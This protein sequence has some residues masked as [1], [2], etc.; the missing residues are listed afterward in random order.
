MDD[1][2]I[3]I[4]TFGNAVEANLAK[5]RL[6]TAGIRA[7]LADADTVD[8][9]W[10]LTG[11]VGGIKLQIPVGDEEVALSLLEKPLEA[12]SHRASGR[13]R[14]KTRKVIKLTAITRDGVRVA[15]EPAPEADEEDDD[16]F[17]SE[18]EDDE[19]EEETSEIDQVAERAWRGALIGILFLPIQLYVFGLLLHVIFSR[20][21]PSPALRWKVVAAAAINLPI[22]FLCFLFLTANNLTLK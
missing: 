21:K 10:Q 6:E 17:F 5:N 15:T 11:A 4:A 3:T 12:V 19:E 9:A 8:M 22:L 20:E 2:L 16:A 7:F 18:D 14:R 1:K 13:P